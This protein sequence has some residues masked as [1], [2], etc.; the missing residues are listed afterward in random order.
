MKRRLLF[1]LPLAF[2]L[3]ACG[4]QQK[5]EESAKEAADTTVS[6][7]MATVATATVHELL[8]VDGSYVLSTSDFARL[9]PQAAGRLQF[10]YVKEGDWVK[11][12]QLLA[13]IDTSVLD[14]QRNSASA[15]SA[16]AAAQAKQTQAALDAARSDYASG[17]KLAQLNLQ[18]T[19][20][21]Q[22]SNIDQAKVD[23]DKLKAGAR[24]Q[25]ISQAEQAVRQAQVNRDKAL[26]DAQ[27]D[28]KLLAEGYV[29]GQQADASQAAYDVAESALTQAKAQLDLTRQGARK[30][31]LK[32]AELRY[33][34]AKDLGAKRIAA[35]KA[36]LE[37]A[38]QGHFSVTSKQQEAN[39]ASLAAAGKRADSN[40]A[41]SQ[42][43]LG[44]VRAPFDGVVTKRL[45]G[46]GNSVDPTSAILEIAKRG[47]KVEFAGQV[48]P[49]NAASLHDGMTVFAEGVDKQIGSIRSVGVADPQS[50]QVPVRIVFSQPP[51][52]SASGLYTRVEVELKETRDATVVPDDAIVTREEKKVVFVVESGVAKMHEVETGASEHGK[53][54]I[55]KGVKLGDKVVLVGQHE[56][57]DGAKVEDAA[58]K[59]EEK[60]DDGKDEKKDEK[61]GDDK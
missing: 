34:S 19:I 35:A 31:E 58:A 46:P 39:A 32:A 59:K 10:V 13:K 17:V 57:A 42:A 36:A 26:A 30:E 55:E 40:A 41:A 11:K 16:S 1:L 20:S 52:G 21:E 24:P 6:V 25:E 49:R 47:A 37:Q 8:P 3:A 2:V 7:D 27:R 28:K 53:T 51:A 9:A 38:Q 50:G 4:S 48:S 54:A 43:A 29:S 15:G 33:Q 5:S 44:E 45:L 56:L 61:K 23:L 22:T 60:K 18:A 14:A 12:G